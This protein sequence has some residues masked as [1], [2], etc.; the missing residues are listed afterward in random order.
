[1]MAC[2]YGCIHSTRPEQPGGACCAVGPNTPTKPLNS[3]D[4]TALKAHFRFYYAS[5]RFASAKIPCISLVASSCWGTFLCT[6]S[7]SRL[8]LTAIATFT[9]SS[10]LPSWQYH[11]TC[12]SPSGFPRESVRNPTNRV[13]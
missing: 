3:S 10:Y 11:C 9:A 1:M 12:F 8:S 7:T 13:A 5:S 4:R 2:G 6:S